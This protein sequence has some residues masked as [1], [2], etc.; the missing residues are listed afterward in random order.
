MEN[1]SI[2]L[3]DDRPANLLALESIL[4][5]FKINIVMATSGNETLKICDKQE[6]A[7][8]LLDVQMPEMDGFETA[9]ML[10]SVEKTRHFPI[11]FVTAI[12]KDQE[13]VFKGYE[14]GAVDYILK[15][16]NTYVLKSKVKVF[17]ELYQQKQQL[18][19]YAQGLEKL[20]QERTAEISVA[21]ERAEAANIAKSEFLA[22]MSHE[23][24]TPLHHILSF[25]RIG[26]SKLDQ[27][28]LEK[29][30]HYFEVIEKTGFRLKTLLDN[31]LDLSLSE[32]GRA[33]YKMLKYDLWQIIEA[34]K[35]EFDNSKYENELIL[36]IEESV[37]STALVCDLQK[38]CQVLRNLL[39]NAIAF[40]PTDEKIVLSIEQSE[41]P[42]EQNQPDVKPTPA[43]LVGV[44]D[45]GVGIPESEL[46]TIFEKFVQSSKTKTGAGGTGLGLAICKEIIKAHRGKIW[47][48]NNPDGGSRIKFILPISQVIT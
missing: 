36:D 18:S 6:F 5:D 48:E 30:Y 37:M 25:A 34:V 7:L 23:L 33:E 45:Q 3:V 42:Q 41:L 39:F 1:P 10:R 21:K 44:T 35:S 13:H 4:D 24:R 38:I 8:I 26:M 14:L 15:P 40:S 27:E 22:N 16:I 31:L 32:S 12:N 20:V 43:I 28:N 11:I 9:E 17:V 2:L 46:E 29:L 47:A 19:T